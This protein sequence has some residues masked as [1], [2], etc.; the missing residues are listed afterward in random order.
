M[1]RL[2]RLIDP[3][4][5][6]VRPA[7]TRRAVPVWIIGGAVAAAAVAAIALG[8]LDQ[9]ADEVAE[10]AAGDEIDLSLFTVS[11]TGAEVADEIEDEYLEAEPGEKIVVL[12]LQLEN[13]ADYPIGVGNA[14]DRVQSRLVNV[15]EPMLA[16]DGA[17][18]RTAAVWRADGSSGIVVLQPDVPAEV[19]VAWYVP[20]D[21]LADGE[22]SLDVYA[23][24]VS[25]GQVILL[26]DV[27]TWHRGD[28][29]ATVVVDAE[30]GA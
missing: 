16:L 26:S 30:A 17:D 21:V 6:A 1:K 13:L 7:F 12:T 2:A 24:Y 8:A 20:D 5:D 10:R 19:Q 22:V 15:T 25:R 11:V 4:R 29:V 14:V 18:D 28:Q 23:P 3:A 9:V 27:V